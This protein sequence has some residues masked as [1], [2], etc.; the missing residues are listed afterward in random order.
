HIPTMTHTAPAPADP[1]SS[2]TS[3][4]VTVI[5]GDGIGPEVVGAALRLMQEAGARLDVEECIAGKEV[6]LAGDQTGVPD[7]TIASI[8]RTGVALKGPL[9]TPIGHG[10]KSANVTLRKLFETYGNIRP[11]REIP[12]LATPYAGR[13]VDLVI[14]RENLEDLYAG[15]EHMQTPG[16]CLSLKV[17]THHGSEK[18]ARLAFEY[19]RSTGRTSVTCAT[20]ANIMKLGE[21]M[22]A[23]T[24]DEVAA[25]YPD[26]E[27]RQILVDN[28]AH[29]LVIRP[30]QFDVIVTTNMNGDIL[31]DL[32]SG[33]VG[34]L[35]FAPSA[36][37]G[38]ETAMFEAVHGS[39]PDI[40]GK[41]IANP[42]ALMLSSAMLLRHVGQPE[43][44][45]A[46]EDAVLF[47]LEE[48]KSL[49]GD[50]VV[51]GDTPVG[52]T[53]FTDAV[54]DNL[55][56]VPEMG[57]RRESRPLVM[58]EKTWRPRPV[59]AK[60]RAV[61]GMEVLLE[62]AKMTAAEV[63]AKVEECTEGSPM[64]LAL[65]SSRGNKVYPGHIDDVEM[66]E[67]WRARFVRAD[68]SIELTDEHIFRVLSCLGDHFRW[69]NV[70]KLQ[71][72]DGVPGYTKVS[73][74]D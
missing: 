47:T 63:G 41:D 71:V 8:E 30:E 28:C 2:R 14:V 13:G 62:E 51:A 3:V 25:E 49:T 73:G 39:A 58:P 68:E 38:S 15:I 70:Q 72:F 17:I 16:V 42:S 4:P 7:D 6:F 5:R 66:I 24:F 45:G 54:I 59:V 9:E 19:A 44:A 56:K 37:I 50:I 29:Q 26:I 43:A 74:E 10:E 36:N 1:S 23:R 46:I 55:G 40:A 64:R 20:K 33:L 60:V 31:S 69:S 35:G 11:A 22:F 57:A 61:V 18:I 21:G 34:G 53:A 12:G 65:I 67:T 32:T 27:A 48:G 52:T